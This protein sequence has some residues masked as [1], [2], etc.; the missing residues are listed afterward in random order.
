M[1]PLPARTVT[2]VAKRKAKPSAAQRDKIAITLAKKLKKKGL[3]SKQTK[4]HG[5][6]YISRGV[7]KKVVEYQSYASGNYRLLDISKAAV[8]VDIKAARAEGYTVIGRKHIVIPNNKGFADRILNQGLLSG[9]KPVKGGQMSEVHMPFTAENMAE[10]MERMEDNETRVNELKLEDERFAFLIWDEGV[11]GM[12]TRAFRD[13]Y[14]M[15]RH[16]R[17][18]NPDLPVGAV[19]FFRLHRDEEDMFIPDIKEREKLNRANRIAKRNTQ[20]RRGPRGGMTRLQWLDV[21]RP[22]AADAIRDRNLAKAA[23]KRERI[24][25]NPAEHEAHK[26][27]ERERLKAYRKTMKEAMER[28]KK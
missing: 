21:Y 22:A 10:L 9:V 2:T 15:M 19:K 24:A 26:A 27:K 25:A 14:E 23:L 3:L 7:L 4:L 1:R 28:Q 16:F 6:K 13:T 8:K 17:H 12:S 20:G 5:G 11:G 18:Y